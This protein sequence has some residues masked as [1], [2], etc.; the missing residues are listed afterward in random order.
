[1]GCSSND[2]DQS[3]PE[4]VRQIHN[5][6]E[7]DWLTSPG[8]YTRTTHIVIPDVRLW[9][10]VATQ[11]EIFS[12]FPSSIPNQMIK[13]YR[14]RSNSDL[15]YEV[16]VKFTQSPV[17]Y[18]LLVETLKCMRPSEM[19][20]CIRLTNNFL[21]SSTQDMALEE[22]GEIP[23]NPGRL[24]GLRVMMAAIKPNKQVHVSNQ[25]ATF[26]HY[27]RRSYRMYSTNLFQV[28]QLIV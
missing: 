12:T 18:L 24:V 1:M 4:P 16:Q 21:N 13:I 26:F 19:D 7:S 6:Y 15:V 10:Q 5:I 27:T 20:S 8:T 3:I 11:A 9:Y 14:S 28:F 17:G 2:N 22:K 23:R 25:Y